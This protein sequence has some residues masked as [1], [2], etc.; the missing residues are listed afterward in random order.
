M[1]LSPAEAE[2]PAGRDDVD[3]GR[4]LEQF[5]HGQL[6]IGHAGIPLLKPDMPLDRLGRIY[7]LLSD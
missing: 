2:C 5:L 7:A 3:A 6:Q 1:G 4:Q